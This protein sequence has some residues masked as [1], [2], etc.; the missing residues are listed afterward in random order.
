VSQVEL[1]TAETAPLLV[2]RYFENG[3]PG[4]IVAALAQSPE[5]AEVVAPLLGA[6]FGPTSMAKRLKEI[7]ILRTSVANSCRYCIETHT[8]VALDS[9][10]SREEVDWLRGLGRQ[11]ADEPAVETALASFSDALERD[12]G[13]AVDRLRPH[14]RD[15]EIVELL[16]LAATT[17]F[18]NR[19][20][21]ALHLPTDPEDLARLS[22]LGL[23]A[24]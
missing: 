15:F 11:P 17:A 3:D 5:L 22:E 20:C 13:S 10:L 9:G 7:V 6:V 23:L 16:T 14:F 12:A 4:P 8:V 2:R 24:G 21:T 19:F 1:I 18:L